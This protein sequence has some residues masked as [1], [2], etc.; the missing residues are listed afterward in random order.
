M[1]SAAIHVASKCWAF[2]VFASDVSSTADASL[3]E[4]DGEGDENDA[5][6]GEEEG[7]SVRAVVRAGWAIKR[8]SAS[9]LMNG[10]L[11]MEVMQTMGAACERAVPVAFVRLQAEFDAMGVS[12][13]P[14]GERQ[15]VVVAKLQAL[16]PAVV[17]RGEERIIEEFGVTKTELASV[18]SRWQRVDPS[19][20]SRANAALATFQ[21]SLQREVQALAASM[22]LA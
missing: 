4:E 13:M 7:P 16:Q 21:T 15:R 1:G 20:P 2:L 10:Q 14:P 18:M 19:I 17:A 5:E 9:L 6:E 11:L 22:S 8:A 12:D 3:E